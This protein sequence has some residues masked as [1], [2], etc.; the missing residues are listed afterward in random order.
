MTVTE[1]RYTAALPG[2]RVM[3]VSGGTITLDAA[4]APYCTATV[5]VPM[6]GAWGSVPVTVPVLGTVQRPQW[7]PDPAA[8]DALDPRQGARVTLTAASGGTERTFNLG[9]RDRRVNYGQGT[10]TLNLASDEAMLAD[11]APLTDDEAPLALAGSLRAV[12]GYVLG[13]AV[14]ATLA[15]APATDR[16]ATPYYRAVNRVLNP[17][18]NETWGYVAGNNTR[19]VGYGTNTPRDAPGYVTWTSE[20]A[21]DAGLLIWVD[22]QVTGGDTLTAR[23]WMRAGDAGRPMRLLLR[24]RDGEGNT[25]REDVATSS[26]PVAPDWAEVTV[27]GRAPAGSAIV[28]LVAVGQAS[29][30][31]QTFAIDYVSLTEGRILLGEHHGSLAP[32]EHYRYE[33]AGDIN[34][35]VSIRTP[36]PEYDRDP[37]SLVWRAGQTAMEFLTPLLQAHGLRLVCDESRVWT[38][39]DEDYRADG[40]LALRTGVNVVDADE[41]VSRDAGLWFDARV[42][43][44]TWTDRDGIPQERVDAYGLPGYTRVSVLEVNAPWPGVGRSEY[45]VRRAAG[46]GRE[47][48]VEA[49][50]VWDTLPEQLTVLTLPDAPD[51]VGTVASVDYDL[52]TDRM[53]ITARAQE[54]AA[55]AVLLLD[56]R[57][58]DLPGRV[59]AL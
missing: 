37:E 48:T 55:G 1:H 25:I 24:W 38:L 44:Y 32:T 39:R 13:R 4:R 57:V 45:A 17:R 19:A 42:T 49:V 40:R 35:S 50:S 3:P 12:V 5:E 46:V 21:G 28:S 54:V 7:T 16:D 59:D 11:H 30:G 53:T 6:P 33:W 8:L 14:G 31:S 23:A 26:P 34:R 41:S 29:S 2:G 27:T 47:V 9:C 36:Y 51:M 18:A 22:N 15:A 52:A 58:L 20:A 56:G 10:V 43:R